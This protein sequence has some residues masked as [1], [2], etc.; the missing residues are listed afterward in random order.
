MNAEN[1]DKF[2]NL[3]MEQLRR[4]SYVTDPDNVVED[5][6]LKGMFGKLDSYFPRYEYLV[7]G[8]DDKMFT[9]QKIKFKSLTCSISGF[10][11]KKDYN[12]RDLYKFCLETIKL[13]E[14]INGILV[15]GVNENI[16]PNLS[17]IEDKN[18]CAIDGFSDDK[19]NFFQLFFT[20]RFEA[21]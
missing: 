9:E 1:L 11:L 6:D 14:E 7:V 5:T 18:V 21:C 13:V 12:Q 2:S 16:P 4:S 8:L 17:M 3:V 19:V 10:L 20:A 15:E